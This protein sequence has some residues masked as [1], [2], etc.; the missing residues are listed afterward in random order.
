LVIV[1]EVQQH[2]IGN[3]ALY[4]SFNFRYAMVIPTAAVEKMQFSQLVLLLVHWVL[5]AMFVMLSSPSGT[6]W[7]S[8]SLGGASANTSSFIQKLSCSSWSKRSMTRTAAAASRSGTLASD[9]S[10]LWTGKLQTP[11][12]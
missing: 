3:P 11:P 1:Y 5:Q 6:P 10:Y 7:W 2:H 4:A 12:A 8:P 9:G